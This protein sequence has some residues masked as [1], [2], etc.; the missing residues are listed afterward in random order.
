[1][2]SASGVFKSKVR[3]RDETFSYTFAKAGTYPYYCSVHPK[4]TG[5]VVVQ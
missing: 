4:M 5:Q 1:V 3:D 2:V